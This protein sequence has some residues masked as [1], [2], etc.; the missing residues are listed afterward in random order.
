MAGWAG[1]NEHKLTSVGQFQYAV[2]GEVLPD[3]AYLS[4]SRKRLSCDGKCGY[5]FPTNQERF[6]RYK[7]RRFCLDCAAKGL[8]K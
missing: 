1:I 8:V 3:G 5:V 4:E 7:T 2:D 6:I